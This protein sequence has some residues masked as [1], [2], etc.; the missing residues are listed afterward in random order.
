MCSSSYESPTSV[1]E[2]HFVRTVNAGL[3]ALIAEFSDLATVS[4]SLVVDMVGV[5]LTN[6]FRL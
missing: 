1:T 4:M 6:K 2:T 3:D 5:L